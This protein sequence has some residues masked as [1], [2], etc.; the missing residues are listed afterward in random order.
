VL[1]G[2]S[3]SWLGDKER[4]W[5]E[6]VSAMADVDIDG[7]EI[8]YRITREAFFGLVR[9][10]KTRSVRI[11][12]LHNFTPIPEGI[13]FHRASGDVFNMASLDQDERRLAIRWT[14]K[15]IELA[16]DLE[17][18]AV[19]V[20]CGKVDVDPEWDTIRAL[21]RKEKGV[22]ESIKTLL[23]RKISECRQVHSKHL[24]ALL[25]SLDEI[26]NYASHLE[27]TVSLENRFSFHELP[28]YEDF[29]FI[30]NEFEGA[31]VTYWHDIGHEAVNVELGL[32]E[33]G[34]CLQ[35]FRHKLSG[36]HVH[37]V[38]GVD[39]HLPL[40][41]GNLFADNGVLESFDVPYILELKAGTDCKHVVES[42]GKL[43]Q[44]LEHIGNAEKG[45]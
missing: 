4:S 25:K 7:V 24:D 26:L 16:N 33:P 29:D 10:L 37:D 14:S 23:D 15:T 44:F 35:R 17:G 27:I 30:F 28:F 2:L 43:R 36:F 42:V 38:E 12:S 31:P 3:T 18:P 32:I 20:H 13:P 39:D 34:F 45:S 11:F 22:S 5:R 6:I 21:Y 8:N 41:R 1:V 9:E 40:G 19:V